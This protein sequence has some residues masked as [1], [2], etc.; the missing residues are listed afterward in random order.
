[1]R[2]TTLGR[3]LAPALLVGALVLSGGTGA[4]AAGACATPALVKVPAKTRVVG[5][6]TAASCTLS[7]L[8]TAVTAGGHVVFNC[9]GATTIAVTSE[10][11]VPRT[12]VIDGAGRIT[13][14]G[15]RSGHILRV[16]VD[17]NL[18]VR[19]MHLTNGGSTSTDRGGAI[20]G[21]YRNQIEVIGSTFT[22]NAVTDAG[23][24]IATAAASRLSVVNSTFRGNRSGNVGGAVYSL[25]SRLTVVGSSFSANSAGTN[26]GAILTDGAA[27]P[28]QPGTIAICGATFRNNTAHGSGG[29]GFF[30]SYAPQKIIVDR[31]TFEG[32]VAANG[33][34]HAGAA[35]LSVSLSAKHRTGTLIVQNSSIRSNSS[36]RDGGAFYLDCPSICEIRNTLF[37][38][39]STGQFGGAVF[40]DGHHDE[41]VTYADNVAGDQG[42]ATFGARNVYDNTVFMGNVAHNQ[43]G[44]AQACNTTGRG[45]H[46]AQWRTTS[47]DTS[48]KCAGSVIAKNPRLAEPARNGGVTLSMMPAAESPLLGAGAD[49]PATDQR[50]V[51]REK[52]RCDIGAVQRTPVVARHSTTPPTTVAPQ[53]VAGAKPTRTMPSTPTSSAPVLDTVA[54][55]DEDPLSRLLWLAVGLAS[56]TAVAS[57]GVMPMA[58]RRHRLSGS[59]RSNRSGGTRSAPRRREESRD[60]R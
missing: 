16:L 13:L 22:G 34:G 54:G 30:W 3:L 5:T 1:M 37:H 60:R 49:C 55:T 51:S 17:A 25:L 38:K 26:G 19:D 27:V 35:R 7:A 6:G 50:G 18:S 56:L 23:G 4:A 8:R 53:A 12:T 24:A 33:E 11:L 20:R 59:H 48:T 39:N 43:W 2:W 46:V 21:D 42:G 58:A 57:V 45:S 52:A 36:R 29:G 44:L 41:N 40:G 47:A 32:N 15:R 9:G 14:D 28:D 31:T 10:I